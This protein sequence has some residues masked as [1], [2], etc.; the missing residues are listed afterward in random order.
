MKTVVAGP[1]L[2]TDAQSVE[3]MN[4]WAFVEPNNGQWVQVVQNRRIPS[5]GDCQEVQRC[6]YRTRARRTT[7]NGTNLRECHVLLTVVAAAAATGAIARPTVPTWR[8]YCHRCCAVVVAGGGE[9]DP[10]VW[11]RRPSQLLSIIQTMH[12]TED[13]N[14]LA[15][16]VCLLLWLCSTQSTTPKYTSISLPSK[17]QPKF[18]TPM[19]VSTLSRLRICGEPRII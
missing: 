3:G 4:S 8:N 7:L 13:S 18:T 10:L 1:I 11:L 12:L 9:D 15:L 17:N 16:V 19:Q 2:L 6:R 14:T 5:S